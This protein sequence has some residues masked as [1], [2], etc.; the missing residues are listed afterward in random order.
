MSENQTNFAQL[1]AAEGSFFFGENL[2]LKDGRPT[3]YFINMGAFNSGKLINQLGI[4][5]A[6]FIME[7]KLTDQFDVIVGPSYKGSSLACT[8]SMALW[9]KFQIDKKFDY[10]RKEIKE[11]GESSAS[12][13]QFVNNNLLHSTRILI[14]DDVASSM[15][16]KRDLLKKIK[17]QEKINQ[18]KLSVMG[19]LLGVDRQQLTV[20]NAKENNSQANIDAI[21][22]FSHET[23][24]PVYHLIKIRD[25][26]N[27][28]YLNK[29][30]ILI[31]K[32]S[33]N[34]K[35]ELSLISESIMQTCQ[36]YWQKYG[37][38]L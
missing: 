36:S 20:L 2:I 37:T 12:G 18:C 15:Q 6:N 26:I 30:S 32:G 33:R 9:N 4:I 31:K 13:S 23:Q 38:E 11:H 8:T 1:L 16:T 3:P 19:V 7:N 35:Q 25:M 22:Y 28:F 29:I 14:I 34:Q 27:Y 24:I 5:Y 10:D 17:Y 21:Q